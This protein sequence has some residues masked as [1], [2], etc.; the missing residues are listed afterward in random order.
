MSDCNSSL[1]GWQL[2]QSLSVLCHLFYHYDL[3]GSATII[4]AIILTVLLLIHHQSS[5][6]SKLIHENVSRH[7]RNSVTHR[8]WNNCMEVIIYSKGC[9][10]PLHGGQE[11]C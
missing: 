11:L 5:V 1:G 3:A 10:T 7:T 2:W 6:S 4:H 8:L 9:Q